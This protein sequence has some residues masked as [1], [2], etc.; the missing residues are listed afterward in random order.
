[1]SVTD[2][3]VGSQQSKVVAMSLAI[4]LTIISLAILVGKTNTSIRQRL[5]VIMVMLMAAIPTSLLSTLQVT[6]LVTGKGEQNE[7]WWC[8]VWA[9]IVC[10]LI[11][12]Y[13][14]FMVGMVTFGMR[15]AL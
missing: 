1:M 14:V 5:F 11:I 6:C 8:N 12:L 3:F 4:T 13:C 15:K 2:V 9:W 7:Q 10:S